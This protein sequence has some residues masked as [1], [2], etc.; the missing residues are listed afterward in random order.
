MFL[1]LLLG[2]K[3]YKIQNGNFLRLNENFVSCSFTSFIASKTDTGSFYGLFLFVVLISNK[4]RD[5]GKTWRDIC[6]FCFVYSY[7]SYNRVLITKAALTKLQENTLDESL[8]LKI[9]PTKD[10]DVWQN[11]SSVRIFTRQCATFRKL[12]FHTLIFN[13]SQCSFSYLARKSRY[14]NIKKEKNFSLINA[15]WVFSKIFYILFNV[16]QINQLYLSNNE[17]SCH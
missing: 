14:Q 10:W 8:K 12:L 16:N 2:L 13:F 7:N 1:V 15:G 5:V 17:A 6:F 4:G 3:L 9:C 11:H